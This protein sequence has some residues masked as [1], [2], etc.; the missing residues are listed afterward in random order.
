MSW[1][2]LLVM[3][4]AEIPAEHLVF[5]SPGFQKL[6]PWVVHGGQSLG[7]PRGWGWCIQVSLCPDRHTEPGREPVTA[8]PPNMTDFAT[9]DLRWQ[10][11][12]SEQE[13]GKQT[14]RGQRGV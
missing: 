3:V 4:P 9:S 6:L 5:F 14:A 1:C 12:L 2:P 11:L 8:H 13:M 7:T 10:A